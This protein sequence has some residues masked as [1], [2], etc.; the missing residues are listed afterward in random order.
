MARRAARDGADGRGEG[1][2]GGD[3]APARERGRGG[4]GPTGR[5]GDAPDRVDELV[6]QWE[7][8][9]PDLDPRPMATLGRLSRIYT[10]ARAR[11]D[12]V[13]AAHGLDQGQFDVLA[14]LRRSGPPY[15]LSPTALS[16][17]LL[18]SSGGMTNRLDRLE[19]AGLVARH[20]D[21]ADR[22]A[23]QI[24]LT[25]K[26]RELLDATLS[27][28]VANEER[29]LAPLT[30]EERDELDRLARKLLAGLED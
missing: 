12:A 1:D 23:L 22:R 18:V 4:D 26:G 11:V 13:F 29:I 15:R 17:A 20:R 25:L 9:R 27:E 28:H 6:A 3:D 7:R 21:P 19:R 5:D 24:E 10:L 2:R 30:R 16:S 8:E 14:T